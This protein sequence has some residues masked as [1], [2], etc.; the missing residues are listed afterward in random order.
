MF[1]KVFIGAINQNK[2]FEFSLVNFNNFYEIS[3]KKKVL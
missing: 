1:E 2:R 3:C